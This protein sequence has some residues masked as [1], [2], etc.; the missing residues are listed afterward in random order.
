MCVWVLRMCDYVCVLCA[1]C[2]CDFVCHVCVCIVCVQRGGETFVLTLFLSLQDPPPI[3]LPFSKVEVVM[4]FIPP[5]I[6][7]PPPPPQP[8]LHVG[9]GD[10]DIDTPSPTKF[11]S[12]SGN[13]RQQL[14][15]RLHQNQPQNSPR[16]HVSVK[17]SVTETDFVVLEDMTLLD[18]NAVVLKVRQSV[19]VLV[20]EREGGGGEGGR[21][22]QV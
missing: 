6:L 7:L 5:P 3:P 8:L 9:V 14:A 17:L 16:R 4:I 12:V 13:L 21:G 22:V 11:P 15:S 19:W 18:S 10:D 1:L 2:M 20:G